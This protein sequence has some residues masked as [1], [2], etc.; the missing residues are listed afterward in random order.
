MT[1]KKYHFIAG[2]PRSGSTL[3]S[4]LLK[5]NPRFN[6]NISSPVAPL[7]SAMIKLVSAGTEISLSLNENQKRNLLKSIFN[8]YYS[9]PC[10]AEVLFDTNRAWCSKMALLDQLFPEAKVIACVRDIPWIMDSIERLL[11]KNPFEN[12]KLFSSESERSTVYS[13]MATLAKHDRL[14]GF[15]WAALK[16]AYYGAFSHKLLLVEYDLLV[17]SPEKVLKLIYQFTEEPWFDGHDFENVD[18]EAP[19]FDEALGLA[20]LHTVRKKVEPIEREPILPPDIFE[21]Y[22]NMAFWRNDE[23]S[24]SSVIKPTSK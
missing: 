6:A 12:T 18:F 24:R 1:E 10:A 22:I 8:A 21:K 4:A 16:E 7:A 20:G 3:L 15:P 17:R 23:R 2:L 9:E 14:I 19:E 13:R 11:L 5:Q